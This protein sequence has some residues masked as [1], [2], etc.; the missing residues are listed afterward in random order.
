MLIFNAYDLQKVFKPRKRSIFIMTDQ[1]VVNGC[2]VNKKLFKFF[3][4]KCL[5]V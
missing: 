1:K 5:K 4:K 3:T 2:Q